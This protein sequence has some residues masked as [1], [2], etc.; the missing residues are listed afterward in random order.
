M[1]DKRFMLEES[2]RMPFIIRYPREIKPGTTVNDIILNIDFAELFLDYAR[3]K[4]PETMQ[5]TS[6]R[7]NLRGNTPENWR[8]AMYYRYWENSPQRPAHYGIRTH[9]Y[10]L[11]YYYGLNSE[12]CWELYDLK[13]DPLE[14]VNI[15]NQPENRDII[16]QLK[17]KLDQLQKYFKDDPAL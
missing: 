2:L 16:K 10:K 11:I 7:E 17:K 1:F 15:Y 8:D 13:N 12:A 9:K 14:Q 5:G 6:F 3:A 4:V